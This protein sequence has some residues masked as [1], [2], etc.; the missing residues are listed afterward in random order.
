MRLSSSRPGLI[1][2]FGFSSFLLLPVNAA[3]EPRTA[4]L[5]VSEREALSSG[6]RIER[7]LAFETAEGAYVGGVAYQVVQR[8]P[9]QILAALLDASNLPAMLPRTQAAR[10]VSVEGGLT[11]IELTQGAAPFLARYTIVVQPSVDGSELRFWLDQR[12]PHDVR[13]VWGF[14]RVKPFGPGRTLLSVGAAVDLGGGLLRPLL[15]AKVRSAVL[16][17]V[18]GIRDFVEPRRLAAV[19]Y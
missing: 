4:A 6:Q 3:A 16:G 9:E 8:A 11:R 7:P 2:V 13:D 19:G 5:G 17:A 12:A 1:A 18:T 10:V 15:D 14:F